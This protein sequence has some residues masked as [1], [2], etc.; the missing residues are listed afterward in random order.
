MGRDLDNQD[1]SQVN[2]RETPQKQ[3]PSTEKSECYSLDLKCPQEARVLSFKG[4]GPSS[5]WLKGGGSFWRGA[6]LGAACLS[7]EVYPGSRKKDP[8]PLFPLLFSVPGYA[9]NGFALLYTP[10]MVCGHRPKAKEPICQGLKSLKRLCKLVYLS[11]ID[12]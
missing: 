10:T 6:E 4:L 11:F 1:R 12:Y 9:V 5:V 8:N 2:I 3:G 7:L